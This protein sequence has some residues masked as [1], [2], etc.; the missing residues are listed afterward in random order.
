VQ[1][2][3]GPKE[4]I[5]RAGASATAPPRKFPFKR[6]ALLVVLLA[7]GVFG[8]RYLNDY[9]ATGWYHIATDDAY[10]RAD[11]SNV[12]AK[13][14]GYIK[15]FP[16]AD[17]SI[18]AADTVI[19]EIDDG[20]YQIALEAAQKKANSQ[21]ATIERF[22]AQLKQADAAVAQARDQVAATQADGKRAEADFVRYTQLTAQKIATPQRLEQAVADRDRTRANAASARSALVS[23]Q[24]AKDV[25]HAQQKEAA[26]LLDE[27][28][29]QVD[30]AK[31]DLGF[32]KVRAAVG[33]VFGNKSSQVGSFV[34]PGTRLGA[35]IGDGSLYVEA[36]FKET[37]LKDMRP[38]QPATVEVDALGGRILHGVVDSF[39]PGS[40]SVFSVLPPE[41]ATGNF[42]KI[43]QR[44]PVRIALPADAKT[45]ELLRPGLS[46]V[47]TVDTKAGTS[48]GPALAA[49]QPQ[50]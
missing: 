17:N 45:I 22:E 32:T 49:K 28:L 30:K 34:E 36:N 12:A 5:D 4:D 35:L 40:G 19:A 39:A 50:P 24:A 18:V 29:V 14:G 47:V 41:N 20:D 48:T 44:V 25:L 26:G 16:V 46:V 9:L 6:L 13:V 27:L 10:V 33:G 15:A 1:D 31:R 3:A 2:A 8:Y 11:I 7:A 42:T 37:Q 21:R 43:V 38:G 23:A